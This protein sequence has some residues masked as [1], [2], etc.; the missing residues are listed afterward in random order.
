L[1]EPLSARH[2]NKKQGA[3]CDNPSLIKI[4]H[5]SQ[6]RTE[7]AILHVIFKNKMQREKKKIICKVNKY[8]RHLWLHVSLL[9]GTSVSMEDR[10]RC[11]LFACLKNKTKHKTKFQVLLTDYLIN[12]LDASQQNSFT[13]RGVTF[14]CFYK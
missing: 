10:Q 13:I 12:H 11:H 3:H 14:I 9:S 7:C 1:T 4:S 6:H 8:P 2:H 5:C